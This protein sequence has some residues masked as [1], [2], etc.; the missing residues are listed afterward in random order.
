[1]TK[2][3]SKEELLLNKKEFLEKRAQD[4]WR[5]CFPGLSASLSEG[6]V[7]KIHQLDYLYPSEP[8][9]LVLLAGWNSRLIASKMKE[10]SHESLKTMPPWAIWNTEFCCIDKREN[11]F[12]EDHM[13]LT[14]YQWTIF[15][16][17]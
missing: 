17:L 7:Q 10:F 2:S 14:T 4:H 9:K 15:L 3:A 5:G 12:N 13:P 8:L 6:G 16:K 1:M 11:R